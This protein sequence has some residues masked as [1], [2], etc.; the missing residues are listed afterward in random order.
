M[1]EIEKSFKKL[2]T[3]IGAAML[4]FLGAF[5]VAGVLI[6]MFGM[7]V[8]GLFRDPTATVAYNVIYAILYALPFAG[9][10]IFLFATT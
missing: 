8:Y 5:T 7:L 3:K 6:E 2:M 4:I 1:N 9:A 10:A